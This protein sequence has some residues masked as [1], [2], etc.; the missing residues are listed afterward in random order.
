MGKPGGG[1]GDKRRQVPTVLQKS[2]LKEM[3]Q[4]RRGIGSDGGK[5]F[6]RRGD[7]GRRETS[8]GSTDCVSEKM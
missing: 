5:M 6:S 2:W 8:F 1:G 3:K 7:V 4:T